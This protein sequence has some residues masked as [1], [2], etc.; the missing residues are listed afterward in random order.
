M[1][2]FYASLKH[3]IQRTNG[4]HYLIFESFS[5]YWTWFN[6]TATKNKMLSAFKSSLPTCKIFLQKF[7]LFGIE[8]QTILFLL[9][10]TLEG[11]FCRT[12]QLNII[13][14]VYQSNKPS[15]F[16]SLYKTLISFLIK[17]L[18]EK[19]KETCLWPL[20]HTKK[21]QSEESDQFSQA[22]FCNNNIDLRNAYRVTM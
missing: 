16:F 22:L 5:D 3:K 17:G 12:T 9:G 15:S 10:W 7:I 2:S 4:T 21:S 1:I 14:N 18:G 19:I 8:A 20:E 11:L 13:L 6:L